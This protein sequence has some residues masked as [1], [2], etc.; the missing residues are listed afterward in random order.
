MWTIISRKSIKMRL[1]SRLWRGNDHKS[2]V[3]KETPTE[4]GEC[5]SESDGSFFGLHLLYQCEKPL[6]E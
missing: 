5:Q 6:I 1:F 3:V 4:D 2:T